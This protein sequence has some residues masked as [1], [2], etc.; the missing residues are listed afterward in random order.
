M[1][2][3]GK[4]PFKTG[5]RTRSAWI[6]TE[7]IFIEQSLVTIEKTTDQALHLSPDMPTELA[8][9]AIATEIIDQATSHV[10]GIVSDIDTVFLHQFR[11]N[12]RKLRS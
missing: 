4:E 1:L 3:A 5:I 8:V 2:L 6:R 7:K 10:D 11:V 12:V 9:R